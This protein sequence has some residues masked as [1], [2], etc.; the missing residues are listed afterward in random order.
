MFP[1]P[2]S[3][4]ERPRGRAPGSTVRSGDILGETGT[5]G[6][7]DVIK[8]I[9]AGTV[10]GTVAGALACALAALLLG[11]GAVASGATAPV[12]DSL[13]ACMKQ[14]D[15]LKRLSCYDGEMAKLV[16]QAPAAAPA[17][18]A[19]A[20]PVAAAPAAGAAAA[21]SLGSEQLYKSDAA[22]AAAASESRLTARIAELRT[23][24]AGDALITLDN[25][26]V[27][28]Q[29]EAEAYFPLAVGDTVRIEK[30]ALGSYRL[31]RVEEGWKRWMRVA[32]VK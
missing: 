11:T 21:P 26:Q 30:G 20:A 31:S 6:G 24:G 3:L 7:H 32:R 16:A 10:N 4:T 27:W 5:K 23:V 14:Q 9:P 22:I 18:P 17:V 1:A 15:V 13:R 2:Q 19:P 28:R 25:G 12:P 29:K 8:R